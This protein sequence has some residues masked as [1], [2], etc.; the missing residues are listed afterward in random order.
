MVT[1][2]GAIGIW[3]V[4]AI[5]FVVVERTVARGQ[6]WD[7]TDKASLLV[8]MYAFFIFISPVLVVFCLVFGGGY[9]TYVGLRRLIGKPLWLDDSDNGLL[10]HLIKRRQKYD[11]RLSGEKISRW[12]GRRLWAEPEAVIFDIIV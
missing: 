11:A 7:A 10:A 12:Q 8:F 1:V 2:Y 5:A 6:N 4:C 9:W 3:L